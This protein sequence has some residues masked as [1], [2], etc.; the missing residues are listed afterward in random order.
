MKKRKK[1]LSNY[2]E[3]K[4]YN[5]RTSGVIE[6]TYNIMV[7]DPDEDAYTYNLSHRAYV[8]DCVVDDVL[9]LWVF[10]SSGNYTINEKTFIKAVYLG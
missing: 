5:H 10:V 3:E 9:S 7:R 8:L 4:V 2:T 6:E 1:F